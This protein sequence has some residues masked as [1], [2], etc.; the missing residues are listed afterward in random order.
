M[1][2]NLSDNGS[3]LM[4]M[5]QFSGGN[6]TYSVNSSNITFNYYSTFACMLDSGSTIIKVDMSI[7]GPSGL[8]GGGRDPQ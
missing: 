4:V 2:V 3:I 8:G 1:P 7:G 6:H 5:V